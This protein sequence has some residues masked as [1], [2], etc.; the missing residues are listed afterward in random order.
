MSATSN[1][2]LTVDGWLV[3]D[4]PSQPALWS[5]ATGT[6]LVGPDGTERL[7]VR[8]TGSTGIFSIGEG[9]LGVAGTGINMGIGYNAL[10]A[11]VLRSGNTAIGHR[12]LEVF[13]GPGSD[14][15]AVGVNVLRSYVSGVG[16]TAVG[17]R[18]QELNVDAGN[19]TSV[20]D[21]ALYSVTGAGIGNTAMGY[22]AAENLTTGAYNAAFGA[23]ALKSVTTGSN[24]M[25]I[26]Y[27]AMEFAGTAASDDVM[28]GKEAGYLVSGVSNVGIGT[29][30]LKQATSGHYNTAIGAEAGFAITTGGG[31][32]FIGQGAGTGT[33]LAT[34]AS[35]IAIGRLAATTKSYQC[36]IGH[37]DITETLLR[38]IICI[39]GNT[40]ASPA[41]KASSTVLQARLGDDSGFAPLQGQLRTHANAVAETPT[42]TH[43]MVMYDAGGTAYRVPCVV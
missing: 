4:L 29:S 33:Q 17:Y 5:D 24:N 37:T 14:N 41:V 3:P 11:N 8:S 15:T 30:A 16:C 27:S 23:G 22:V 13:V 2:T 31:N 32:T 43:T 19:N 39:G 18:S 42:P 12:A 9:A 34:A 36:V 40:S 38:G 10:A 35:S 1:P 6:A 21:S 28:I 26:G 7:T 20:G 25:A